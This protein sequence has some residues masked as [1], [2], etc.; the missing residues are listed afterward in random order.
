MN[1]KIL[2]KPELL[3][4]VGNWA[5]LVAAIESGADAVYLGV[6]GMNMRATAKNFSLGELEK[7]VNYSHK[8]G[9]KLY[10]TVN[11]IVYE[12][13]L[14]KLKS[15][16]QKAKD[17]SV[18]AIICWDFAVINLAKE[19]GIEFHISTQA[20]ISNSESANFFSK[21]GATRCVLARECSLE[22]LKKIKKK[23]KIGIEVFAH[24]AMCVSVSGRCFISESIYGKSANR[25][26][27]LQPCRRAYDKVLIKDKE[28]D[29]ELILGNDYVMSPKDLCTFEFLDNILPFVD[30]LKI[31]GRGKSPEYVKKVVSVYRKG[32]D[33]ILDNTFTKDFVSE[34]MEELHTTFNRGFSTGFYM[35]KPISEFTNEYGS[36]SKKKKYTLGRVT[37][38]YKKINVADIEITSNKIK[39]G[40]TIIIIGNKTGV[41]EQVVESIITES[42]KK[43]GLKGDV[44]SIKMEKVV[45][46]N[47]AVFL[48]K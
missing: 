43:I 40:D 2:R 10:L 11:T 5:M 15:I 13:E 32:I 20:S 44:A 33:R 23:T 9:V 46:K 36:K 30:S 35:G 7:I 22:D 47:D 24:G 45:R 29:H 42:K 37:N 31:E 18:D 12:N 17:Y 34:K 4:P 1:N 8:K 38:F 39:K 21:L 25:G 27:C 6:K 16:L 26:D 28:E 48:W 3:A 19:I 14:T 41:H